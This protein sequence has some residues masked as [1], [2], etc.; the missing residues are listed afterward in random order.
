MN[1]D[2]LVLAMVALADL[3]VLV[4]LRRRRAQR[5]RTERVLRS[6]E[7]AVR[8]EISDQPAVRKRWTLRR[9]L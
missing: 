3:A 9:P 6:M 7:F 1:A 5:N 8:R 2:A 4:H